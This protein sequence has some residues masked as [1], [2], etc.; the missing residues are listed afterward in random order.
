M[1]N[2]T[3]IKNQTNPMSGDLL[4]QIIRLGFPVAIQSALV[5]ILA[6]ADVLMVS[7]FGKEATA[8]VGIASKWHFVAIMIM[9][10]LA[11]ANGTLVAQYW[12]RNDAV[13]A[14]TVTGIAIRF[15]LKVLIP[16]TLII[17]L[18]SELIMCLQT[19]DT[20]VIELG[21]TYLWYAFPVLLLTHIVIVLEASM[22]SSGDTVTPLLM[23][24]MTIVLNI[25]L[26]FWLIKGGFGIPAMG[27]AG[28]AF[29]T[30]ISRLFQVLAMI[31]TC[32]GGGTG[33]WK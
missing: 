20:R 24:A 4:R 30:T 18:G 1:T 28:A 17:T 15:G 7:D 13:S 5:A 3:D 16:V 8:A 27:V 26:N 29:A 6:L 11:S 19:S 12:G 21:A 22:R 25:G 33:C 23:G 32:V 14:K 10:G 9:A 2:N 31:A